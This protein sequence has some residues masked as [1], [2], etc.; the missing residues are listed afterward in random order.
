MHESETRAQS[1]QQLVNELRDGFGLAPIARWS[2]IQVGWTTNV[3][4]ESGTMR[5]VARIHR[6]STSVERVRA[7][8]AAR[9]ALADAGVPTVRP[10]QS[11]D[12]A[13]TIT[14]TSGRVAELEKF[15]EWNTRMNTAPLL[16]TGHALMAQMH[17][18]LRTSSLPAAADH[19]P[20]ANHISSED[21]LSATRR[22]AERMRG[23]GRPE[24]SGFAD[25]VVAH[26]DAVVRAEK[27]LRQYQL[28][29]HTHGDF[30][31]NNVLFEGR[32]PVLLLDF[33]FLALRPR[34]DDLALSAYFYLLG[35][36]MRESR[37]ENRQNLRSFLDA[38]DAAASIPLAP[39]E[40]AAFPPAI[41]RQPAWSVGGWV[42]K[43]SEDRAVAHALDAASEFPVAKAVLDD[44]DQWQEAM[45]G[46][47][48]R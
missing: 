16:R 48:A 42:L 34:V 9:T 32:T 12:G 17:D 21:A 41:A 18:G 23:W 28:V 4:L 31:D 3:L 1:S 15:V 38:Y 11:R 25:A 2:D 46:A 22:G 36:G 19:M 27:P 8:Q 35:P 7:M 26:V 6:N 14:L 5:F 47:V 37:D 44:L 40:R 24:L 29:Q 45:T 20:D 10:I 43:Y 30:W 33:D 39:E 13:T